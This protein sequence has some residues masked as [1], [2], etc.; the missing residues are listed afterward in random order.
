MAIGFDQKYLDANFR[1]G[2]KKAVAEEASQSGIGFSI[3][4][5]QKG[6]FHNRLSTS[7]LE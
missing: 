2:G 7:F 3:C 4:R 1:K 5:T 6:Y